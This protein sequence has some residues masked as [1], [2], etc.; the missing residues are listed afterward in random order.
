MRTRRG[1]YPTSFTSNSAV[2]QL[3]ECYLAKVEAASSNLVCGTVG[4]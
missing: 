3:V 2:T 1:L 4:L